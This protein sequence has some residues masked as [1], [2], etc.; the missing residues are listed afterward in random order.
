MKVI[1]A[2]S[3]GFCMGVKRAV[4]IAL[5]TAESGEPV[6]TCGPLI[7]NDQ[8]VA[9]LAGKGVIAAA[10]CDSVRTGTVILRAHGMPKDEIEKLRGKGL[11]IIDATCPH[12]VSSQKIIASYAKQGYFIV[13]VGDRS[14]PEIQSLASFAPGHHTLIGSSREIDDLPELEQAIVI[15][16]TTFNKAEY[17]EISQILKNRIEECLVFDSICSAT[18][19]RQAEVQELSERVDAVVVVGGRNSAN[20]RRLF[21]IAARSCKIVCHVETAAELQPAKFTGCQVVGVTAGAS[22]PDW[23]TDEVIRKL[24]SFNL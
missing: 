20:T 24:E 7:H 18:S 14:H 5:E 6:S 16:Q 9:D 12:V 22:T 11:R 10:D 17:R 19:D 8:V 4:Q 3:A 21:E 1:L 23:I 2:K 15:C 13:I